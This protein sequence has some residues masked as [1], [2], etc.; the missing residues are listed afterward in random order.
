MTTQRPHADPVAGIHYQCLLCGGHAHAFTEDGGHTVTVW[1]LCRPCNDAFVA[2]AERVA[3]TMP[4]VHTGPAAAALEVLAGQ[5]E[6]DDEHAWGPTAEQ[7]RAWDAREDF[8]R[9]SDL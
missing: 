5:L 6:L 7:E 3:A 8:I 4:M 1:E 9:G 2:A